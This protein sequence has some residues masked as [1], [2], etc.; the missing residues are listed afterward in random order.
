MGSAVWRRA[1]CRNRD[2]ETG[3]GREHA[4]SGGKELSGPQRRRTVA[5]RARA[6]AGDG[7]VPSFVAYAGETL[8]VRRRRKEGARETY[9]PT[10]F[11]GRK[12]VD[13]SSSMNG[14]CRGRCA[15]AVAK[16]RVRYCGASV[17]K[18]VFAIPYFQIRI[19]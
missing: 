2:G 19:P 9:F 1:V 10:V 12:V 11:F 5:E 4:R 3:S 6:A 7:R 18:A 8:R 13:T 16:K 17:N 15:R 14:K